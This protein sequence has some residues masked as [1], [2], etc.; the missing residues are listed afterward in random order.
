M[1]ISYNVIDEPIVISKG[2]LDLLLKKE[3]PADCIALYTFLYYTAKWQ[4]T[5][6][7][8]ATVSYIAKALNWSE[9]RVRKTKAILRELNLIE[10][11]K[12]KN[13]SGKIEGHYLKVNFIWGETKTN[14]TL[15]PN[16]N[17]QGGNHHSMENLQ[18]NALN[19]VNKNAL[20][21]NNKLYNIAEKS[22]GV[23]ENLKVEDKEEGHT[24][25]NKKEKPPRKVTAGSENKKGDENLELKEFKKII[26]KIYAKKYRQVVGID[27][28]S[29]EWG[30]LMKLS[31]KAAEFFLNQIQ[32]RE[33]SPENAVFRVLALINFAF[34]RKKSDPAW[35]FGKIAESYAELKAY[36]SD[37]RPFYKTVAEKSVKEA[38]KEINEALE[39]AKDFLSLFSQ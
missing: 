12:R 38:K 20:S 36:I 33:I 19:T 39:V 27:Y 8:K 37:E 29:K 28:P 30:K 25:N 15:H 24:F 6:Q 13:K 11:V 26:A 18:T 3:N 35:I 2:L 10:D 31:E 23:S 21:T 32:T 14:E 5:N 34:E 1:D 22:A 17:P 7:P 4:G 9:N 16:K